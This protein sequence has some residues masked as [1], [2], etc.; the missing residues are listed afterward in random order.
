MH[1]LTYSVVFVLN[2]IIIQITF[3]NNVLLKKKKAFKLKLLNNIVL[4]KSRNKNICCHT[5]TLSTILIFYYN[6][7]LFK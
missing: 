3:L 4:K 6:L 5:Q 1:S 2:K 7:H